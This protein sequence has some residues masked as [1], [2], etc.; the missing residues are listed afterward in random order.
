MSEL[1]EIVPVT[2][3]QRD[4]IEKRAAEHTSGHVMLEVFRAGDLLATLLFFYDV[5]HAERD[6]RSETLGRECFL[7]GDIVSTMRET[8]AAIHAEFRADGARS[9]AEVGS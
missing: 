4:I 7:S 1:Y 6:R 2:D 8:V 5:E 3:W 9:W